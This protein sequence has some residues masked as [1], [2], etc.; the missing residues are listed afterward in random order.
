MSLDDIWDLPAEN[1]SD[2]PLK[3]IEIDDSDDEAPVGPRKAKRPLFLPS[4]SDEDQ[5]SASKPASRTNQ[6]SKSSR[7]EIDA[8]FE[9]LDNPEADLAPALDLEALR[10]EADARNAKAAEKEFALPDSSSKHGADKGKGEGKGGK[11]VLLDDDDEGGDDKPKKKRKPLPKMDETRLL[12][13]DGFPQL[14]KDTKYFKPKGKG[15]EAADLD[16]VLQIYQFWTHRM[17]PKTKFRDTVERVEK[18][19]HSRRVQVALSVWR[20]ES[21]GLVN[22]RKIP[23]GEDEVIDLTDGEASDDDDDKPPRKTKS[24]KDTSPAPID[25]DS[26]AEGLLPQHIS[27]PPSSSSPT[28]APEDDFDLDALLAQE[29][30]RLNADPPVTRTNPSVGASYRA[31]DVTDEDEAMWDALDMDLDSAPPPPPASRPAVPPPMVDEDEDMWDVVREM[32]QEQ[33]TSASTN[34]AASHLPR[35]DQVPTSQAAAVAKETPP[36]ATNDEGWDDMYL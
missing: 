3:P 21:K 32:E 23:D 26:D 16:R 29:E 17:Y 12:G 8:L 30:A 20:D 31:P 9:D 14:V 1:A 25:L 7:P 10:R 13:K 22:G 2:I 11:D 24:A 35:N 4:D 6:T 28:S 15:Y 34:A 5:A 33:Q 19:C 18:L 27:V 36:R